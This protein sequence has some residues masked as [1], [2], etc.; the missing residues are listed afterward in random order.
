MAATCSVVRGTTGG[1][2]MAG[3]LMLTQ[4]DFVM[5]PWSTADLE[6]VETYRSMTSTVLGDSSSDR[7]FTQAC[8]SLRAMA[9]MG[10]LPNVG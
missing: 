2:T 9:P 6:I 10:F 3:S 7:P 1:L 4:G 8:T 5:I